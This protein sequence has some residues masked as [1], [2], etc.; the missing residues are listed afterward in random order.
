MEEERIIIDLPPGFSRQAPKDQFHNGMYL[1]WDQVTEIYED[2]ERRMHFIA[3]DSDRVST[4]R[5]LQEMLELG[6]LDFGFNNI[7]KASNIVTWYIPGGIKTVEEQV[8]PI[9]K[10]E[11][12][13]SFQK[14]WGQVST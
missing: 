1:T 5:M 4:N 9:Y 7:L 6:F 8:V 3:F 10:K 2:E 12:E 14:M 11:A 13:E